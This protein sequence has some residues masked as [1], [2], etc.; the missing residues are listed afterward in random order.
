MVR[1]DV[2]RG[3]LS[4]RLTKL[5]SREEASCRE[6]L[7][8]SLAPRVN[9]VGGPIMLDHGKKHIPV[10]IG[11]I[12]KQMITP[13]KWM[14]I[15]GELFTERP[16]VE[17]IH[18]KTP[19]KYHSWSMKWRQR[20][21]YR[22]D[23]P[24]GW[25]FIEA[26][27]TDNPVEVGAR[28]TMSHS[29]SGERELTI[30]CRVSALPPLNRCK[31]QQQDAED[32]VSACIG[33]FSQLKAR[34]PAV[35]VSSNN[36][37]AQ[38]YSHSMSTAS[39]SSS[40][41]PGG[42]P[43]Q[44]QQQSGATEKQQQ[45]QQSGAA[46]ESKKPKVAESKKRPVVNE[47]EHDNSS[48]EEDTEK[49]AEKNDP[50]EMTA[51]Y[52]K[53]LKSKQRLKRDY[54]KMRAELDSLRQAKEELDRSKEE[55]RKQYIENN[56]R[57]AEMAV[58]MFSKHPATKDQKDVYENLVREMAANEK[59]KDAW[60][61]VTVL[62]EDNVKLS[63]QLNS[64]QGQVNQL[65]RKAQNLGA[66]IKKE[67]DQGKKDD[68]DDSSEESDEEI[69]RMRKENA[70]RRNAELTARANVSKVEQ[71][72]KTKKGYSR[73]GKRIIEPFFGGAATGGRSEVFAHSKSAGTGE[74]FEVDDDVVDQF[75]QR[76]GGNLSVLT[77]FTQIASV[78]PLM[79]GK[80]G[81]I[82]DQSKFEE[83]MRS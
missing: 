2:R 67:K 9:M 35:S 60:K 18:R 36:S 43:Q 83:Y 45:Q 53:A 6:G 55:A 48:S 12:T 72:I 50:A 47:E 56:K 63:Q 21:P 79:G 14:A 30:A 66:V 34:S 73:E 20:L 65:A 52:H 44:Q 19:E 17:E 5:L 74:M 10:P 62:M 23:D 1:V 58:E 71:G 42:V 77:G 46:G 81:E 27:L 76:I 37:S 68:S 22:D 69:A 40:G 78:M 70:A 13:D 64:N 82:K 25:E 61:I 29:H 11:R 39:S 49:F 54:K 75:K 59:A 26:S 41:N 33:V 31:P 24:E 15:D 32:P 38:V 4:G 57:H 80:H 28:V 7:P 3:R 16:E 51:S 8:E